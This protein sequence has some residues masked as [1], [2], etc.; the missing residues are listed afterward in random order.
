MVVL[1]GPPADSRSQEAPPSGAG[2]LGAGRLEEPR[3]SRN[4]R[5]WARE[6][7]E[8]NLRGW[9]AETTRPPWRWEVD[10]QRGTSIAH[11]LTAS[12]AGSDVMNSSM[13]LLYTHPP[14]SS[15]VGGRILPPCLLLKTWAGRGKGCSYLSR[16]LLSTVH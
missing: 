7:L 6:D 4:C 5:R 13:I 2:S 9:E 10:A 8:L 16:A 1:A 3:R 14:S 12:P 15:P 11:G